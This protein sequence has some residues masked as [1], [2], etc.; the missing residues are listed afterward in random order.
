MDRFR[1]LFGYY[2]YFTGRIA[3]GEGLVPEVV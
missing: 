1:W 2:H 3:A